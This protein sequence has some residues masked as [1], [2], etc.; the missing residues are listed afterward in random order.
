ME[1]ALISSFCSVKRIRVFDSP[2]K[3]HYYNL[4]QVSSQLTLVLIYKAR[5]M[6]SWVTFGRK[7][8]HTDIQISAEPRD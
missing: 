7:E 6:E 1:L 5:R 2:W 8:G 4:S 3:G